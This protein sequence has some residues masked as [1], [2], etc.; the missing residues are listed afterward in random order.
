VRLAAGGGSLWRHGDFMRLWAGQSISQFGSQISQLA[1]PLVAILVLEASAF[2]VAL[3]GALEFLPFLLFALPAGVWVDRLPRRPIL[4]LSDVGRALALVSIPIAAAADAIT[5]WQLYAVG[6]AVGTLTVTFD[7]AYQS[8]LPAL[9]GRGQ[10][11]EGNSKLELSRS[12]AQIGGPGVGGLLVAALTAP[13]AIA[14]DAISFAA[15]GIFLARIRAAEPPVDVERRSLRVELVEGLRYLFGDPRWR[16][17]AAYVASINFLSSGFVF[18]ILLVFAVRDLGL[19]AAEIGLIFAASNAGSVVA[20][21]TAQ[22]IARRFGVGPTLI[23]CGMLSGVPLLLLP[24]ATRETAIPLLLAPL[25]IEAFAIVL[26]NVTGISYIQS[27]VPDRMLGRMTAS[28]RFVVWGTIPLGAVAGGALA[29]AIGLRETILVG[30][31][32]STFC[33]LFLVGAPIRSIRSAPALEG[34]A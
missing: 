22:R 15:S 26:F 3:L 14:A 8:Y 23:A 20:A 16:A 6:F 24:L 1:L 17:F 32:G 4:V 28:R 27:V 34:D 5:I 29:S 10:L 12:A 19:S 31:I 18:S 11:V 33:F 13:Y 21:L 7:V 2:E 30:A 9:V 25:V